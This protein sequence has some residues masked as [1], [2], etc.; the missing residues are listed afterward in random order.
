MNKRIKELAIKSGA[1]CEDEFGRLISWGIE[2]TDL[3]DEVQKFA[4]LIIQE[5]TDEVQKFAEFIIQ[6]CIDQVKLELRNNTQLLSNPPQNGGV[7]D[8]CNNIRR[9]FGVK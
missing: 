1:F 9:R 3:T 4:E 6:E 7:W 2:G 8:A 5:C